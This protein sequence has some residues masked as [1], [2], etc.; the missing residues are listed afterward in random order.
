MEYNDFLD[1]LEKAEIENFADVGE[2]ES[3]NNTGIIHIKEFKFGTI[4]YYIPIKNDLIF[5]E[6][7]PFLIDCEKELSDYLIEVIDLNIKPEYNTLTLKKSNNY[8]I[9][10]VDWEEII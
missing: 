3:D 4:F 10:S 8:Y 7:E 1:V 2:I 9:L 6:I 5:E